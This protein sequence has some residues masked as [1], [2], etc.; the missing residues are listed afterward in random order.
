M[1]TSGP[2]NSTIDNSVSD[3]IKRSAQISLTIN[4]AS[5]QKNIGTTIMATRFENGNG[6]NTC[7]LPGHGRFKQQ[8]CDFHIIKEKSPEKST[9]YISQGYL[10]I[11]DIKHFIMLIVMFLARLMNV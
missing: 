10:P 2:V 1:N 11:K 4:F 7:V 5:P 8:P 6:K 3:A 9:L